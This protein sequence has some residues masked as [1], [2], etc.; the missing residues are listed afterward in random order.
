VLLYQGESKAPYITGCFVI[1]G[2]LTV[3]AVTNGSNL[4]DPRVDLNSWV[5]GGFA[6]V[7]VGMQCIGFF[8][9]SK[10]RNL[11]NKREWH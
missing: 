5:L 10:V 8:M 1:G 9:F 7:C 11:P 3:Y 2:L 4:I 6:V